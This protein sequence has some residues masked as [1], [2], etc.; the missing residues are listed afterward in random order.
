MPVYEF[1]NIETGEVLEQVLKISEYDE[2][3]KDNPHLKRHYSTAPS[4][5]SGSKS[6]L[7]IAGSEWKDHLGRIKKGAGRNNTIKT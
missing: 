3:V 7:T 5:T 6:A 1:S 2:Y 4:L